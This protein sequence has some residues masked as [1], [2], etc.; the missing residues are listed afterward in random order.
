MPSSPV[1]AVP[2]CLRLSHA[3]L[4]LPKRG[5]GAGTF[6]TT[7]QYFEEIIETEPVVRCLGTR[8]VIPEEGRK[9][10]YAGR[11]FLVLTEPFELQRGHKL[12]KFS[13]SAKKPRK[14][15]TM[16]QIL[17]TITRTRKEKD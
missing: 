7:M 5:S 3:R 15:M 12:K 16:L 4:S 1:P 6:L 2:P 9:C 8:P 11:K 13:A 14:V 17:G 10:G